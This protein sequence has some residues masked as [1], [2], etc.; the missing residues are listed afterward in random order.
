MTQGKTQKKKY[1]TSSLKGGGRVLV[2][3]LLTDSAARHTLRS[4][5]DDLR[6]EKAGD[7]PLIVN[8]PARVDSYKG[9]RDIKSY[10]TVV[11]ATFSD[12]SSTKVHST[13]TGSG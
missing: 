5:S 10:S 2:L 8:H 3:A 13:K 4:F 12:A 6:K 7:L 1:A 11:D 9:R